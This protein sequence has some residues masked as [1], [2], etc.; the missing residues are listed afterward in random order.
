M[1]EREIKIVQVQ[2]GPMENGGGVSFWPKPILHPS[3]STKFE[4]VSLIVVKPCGFC[5]RGY[6][7]GDVAIASCKHTYRPFYLAKVVKDNN[8]CLI[9]GELFHPNWFTSWGFRVEDEDMNLTCDLGLSEVGT[10]MAKSLL[11]ASSKPILPS[12]FFS[13][14]LFIFHESFYTLIKLK[15]IDKVSIQGFLCYLILWKMEFQVV[16]VSN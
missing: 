5:G 2:L 8:K 3:S 4:S 12:E 11:H 7:F 16:V 14:S 10:L 9:C 6:H 15:P 13:T 1:L